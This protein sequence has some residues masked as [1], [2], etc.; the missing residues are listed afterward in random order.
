ERRPEFRQL[1]IGIS[2]RR[3]LPPRGTAGLARSLVR[4][5]SRVPAPPPITIDK[6][7][8]VVPGGSEGVKGAWAELLVC[9][10]SN[11]V[12]TVSINSGHVGTT[13]YL[14]RYRA[15]ILA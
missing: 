6:T 13:T 14:R 1:L 10:L 3:Y 8:C 11:C 9:R 12:C 7:R 4:G 2:T 5:N 15:G